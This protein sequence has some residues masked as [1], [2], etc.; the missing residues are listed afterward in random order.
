MD[1]DSGSVTESPL[2][3]STALTHNAVVVAPAADQPPSF[4]VMKITVGGTSRSLGLP[5][6]E[7]FF[8]DS[9]TGLFSNNF[10]VQ[11]MDGRSIVPDR[12]YLHYQE[13]PSSQLH[14]KF[15]TNHYSKYHMTSSQM[16]TGSKGDIRGHQQMARAKTW[17]QEQVSKLPD[18]RNVDG[19]EL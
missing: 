16:S 17:L 1:V 10:N 6:H 3:A 5:I 14:A 7:A 18:L 11:Q 9:S 19:G 15:R 12:C 13:H 8:S 2:A 4:Y